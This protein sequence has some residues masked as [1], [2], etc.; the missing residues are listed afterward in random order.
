MRFLAT[1]INHT[2]Y[3]V[4]TTGDFSPEKVSNIASRIP[5]VVSRDAWITLETLL[6]LTQGVQTCLERI[7]LSPALEV[8]QLYDILDELVAFLKV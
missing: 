3:W 5:E 8:E 7:Q 6:Y 2:T 4:D 1:S